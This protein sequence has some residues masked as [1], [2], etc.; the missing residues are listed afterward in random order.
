MEHKKGKF[1][2]KDIAKALGLSPSTVS[3]ALND[4]H[5]I[6]RETK[7]KVRA[8]ATKVSYS[9]DPIAQS[10]KMGKS[11]IIGIIVCSVDNIYAA[12]MLDSIQ[13]ACNKKGYSTFI[14]PSDESY[15]IEKKHTE[16][17]LS[18][19]IDGL[20]ISPASTTASMDHL[21]KALSKDIPVVL[22][23]RLLDGLNVSKVGTKNLEGAYT[24]TD[25]LVKNGYRKI[26]LL[27]ADT[28]LNIHKKRLEGYS[29]CITD[30]GIPINDDYIK[31]CDVQNRET[32]R[33]SIGKALEELMNLASPPDAVFSTTDQITL[34]SLGA[35]RRMGLSIPGD[36]ALIGFSNTELADDLNPALSTV[37][38]PAREL[39]AIAANML[40][41]QINLKNDRQKPVHE[42]I[43]L[44]TRLVARASTKKLR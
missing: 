26:A 22:F 14:M 27:H 33:N 18:R 11:K 32:L 6:S 39:A 4:S 12:Q 44:D 43:L 23:D 24:A 40:F 36:L 25:H 20:L 34:L 19:G 5:E 31:Y 28:A 1:T 37:V 9:P 29:Q 38:Q 21:E 15:E 17:L 10:L 13:H 30:H 3:K 8:F 2:L 16:L 35:I 41:E 42:T 7:A